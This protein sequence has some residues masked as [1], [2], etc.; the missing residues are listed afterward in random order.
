[1]SMI[2]RPDAPTRP[3]PLR[4][5]AAARFAA[6][7]ALVLVGLGTLAGWAVSPAGAQTNS[8]AKHG[9]VDV[10]AVNG[11]VDGIEADFIVDTLASAR[12]SDGV[13]GVVLQFDSGGSAVGDERLDQVARAIVDSDVPVSVW[14][15]PSGSEALGGA[16]EL[17][18][19]ADSSGIAPGASIGDVG[20]QRLSVDEFGDLFTGKKAKG[21]EGTLTGQAAVR[22][23]LVTRFSPT[24]G[25]HL[26][27][28][29]GVKTETRTEDG[30]RRTVPLTTVRFSKLPLTT[31]LFHTVA[32]PSVAY[33]LLTI[34]LGL[35]LFE[36]FTA[37]I[38]IA[39]VVGALFTVLGGYGLAELPHAQWA[40]VVFVASFVAFGI[41]V[42]TGIPR[43]WTA[44]GLVG[45]TVSSVFLMTDFRPTWIAL[46]AGIGGIAATMITGM[47]AMVRT[48]FSTPTIDRDW[49][50][51]E[52]GRAATP[53]DPEGNVKVAG[54]LWRARAD[55]DASVPSG[56]AVR[57][58][59]VDGVVLEVEA[60]DTALTDASDPSD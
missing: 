28:L 46:I 23:G 27:N 35:L 13:V 32:S 26:V 15:G 17:V 33:L 10:V 36:F 11:L 22:A 41:D 47:P 38:G 9:C 3:G 52:S 49:L 5:P 40:L 18:Q 56:A 21:L 34:G 14:I 7:F 60:D 30:E 39:G 54:G 59:A 2:V 16:A 42:Q 24:V 43:L 4:R 50:V 55:T 44:I 25:D 8:C 19:V 20:S 37:G 6:R 29:D 45:F 53:I 58:V 1:M 48:R 31:Q 51:G 12:R 57:V